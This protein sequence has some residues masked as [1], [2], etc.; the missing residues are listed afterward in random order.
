MV[1]IMKENNNNKLIELK[2]VDIDDKRIIRKIIAKGGITDEDNE[3]Y[4]DFSFN[5]A[6]LKEPPM[7]ISVP[8]KQVDKLKESYLEYLS[9]KNTGE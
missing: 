1:N 6:V 2:S 4:S 3:S 8:K 5:K 7:V 9:K